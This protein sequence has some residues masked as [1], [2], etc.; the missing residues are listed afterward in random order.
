MSH[1]LKSPKTQLAIVNRLRSAEGH[2][3]AIIG[4]VESGAPC[5]DVLH[6]LDAVEAALCATG[7]ALRYCQFRKSI[8]AI[9][10]SPSA[11]ARTAELQRLTTL[12]GLQTHL[13]PIRIER[14]SK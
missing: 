4:M 10:H 9:R 12:Y 5:E 13:P 2:L 8:E 7:R 6:Q 11:E 14:L 1:R 3:H